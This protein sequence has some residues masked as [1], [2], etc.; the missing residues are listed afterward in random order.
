MPGLVGGRFALGHQGVHLPG[1]ASLAQTRSKPDAIGA[2]TVVWVT[3]G[4]PEPPPPPDAIGGSGFHTLL[5]L[6]LLVLLLLLLRL[7]LLLL[8]LLLLVLGVLLTEI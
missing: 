6:L 5:L 8:L 3:C 1:P 7:L 2:P 4:C